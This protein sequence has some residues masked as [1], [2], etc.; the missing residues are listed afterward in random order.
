MGTNVGIMWFRHRGNCAPV[1]AYIRLVSSWRGLFALAVRMNT[2]VP[3]IL[4]GSDLWIG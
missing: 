2:V 1:G 4:L 3:L